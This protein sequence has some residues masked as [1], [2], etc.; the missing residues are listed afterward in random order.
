MPAKLTKAEREWLKNLQALLNKCPSRRFQGYT[1]G[2]N[3]IVIYD[4][5]VMEAWQEANQ[6]QHLDVGLEVEQ[7]GAELARFEFTF[8]IDSAA[9]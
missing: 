1:I 9:Y 8:Q 4:K 5:D 6:N 2:D 7:A 3:D